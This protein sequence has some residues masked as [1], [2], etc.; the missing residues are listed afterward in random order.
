MIG[1]S[2]I[3]SWTFWFGAAQILLGGI[4][5]LSGLMDQSAAFAL[6]TTGV[7]TIGFRLKT[8]QPITSV[9]PST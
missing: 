5:L 7:G 6:L 3:E 9:T 8:T 1:K 2:L 4:G